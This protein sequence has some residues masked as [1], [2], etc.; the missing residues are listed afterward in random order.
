MVRTGLEPV[1]PGIQI[2][3]INTIPQFTYFSVYQFRHL[4]NLRLRT[5]LCCA[6]HIFIRS[7][8]SLFH[9]PTCIP[10]SPGTTHFTSIE[11]F[12][13]TSKF[14]VLCICEKI[15]L[16]CN[17]HPHPNTLEIQTLTKSI[18]NLLNKS[19]CSVSFCLC[20]HS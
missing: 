6:V 3:A 19:P 4:T 13:Y 5:P 11:F 7:S 8:D 16:F 12:G 15:V 1:L 9:L 18:C 10:L 20:L 2:G 17:K 14:Y